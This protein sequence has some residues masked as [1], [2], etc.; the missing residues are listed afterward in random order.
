MVTRIVLS[1]CCLA[2]ICLFSLP[3]Q[4]ACRDDCKVTC[5]DDSGLCRSGE[6]ITCLTECLKACG[7][8]DI[9]PAPD[10]SPVDPEPD[11]PDTNTEDSV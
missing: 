1:F 9:P 5:C 2:F 10:P 3:A 4:A 6:S 11:Q 8:D 7:D